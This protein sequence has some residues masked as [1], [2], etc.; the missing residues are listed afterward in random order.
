MI[1]H[2]TTPFLLPR[3]ISQ[4]VAEALASG[5]ISLVR[6]ALDAIRS[7][8]N[9]QCGKPFRLGIVRTFTIETQAEVIALAMSAL[10]CQIEIKIAD[11]ENIEQELVSPAS[12]L[13]LWG[14]DAVVVLWRLEELLPALRF[15]TQTLS[16]KIREATILAL[17][18]RINNLVS[19]YLEV[20]KVPLFISTLPLPKTNDLYDLHE[21]FGQRNAVEVVNAAVFNLVAKNSQISVFDFAGW[22][23]KI[24]SNSFDIKMDLYVRQP[25]ATAAIGDFS[26]FLAR[27]LRPLIMPAAKVLAIDLDNVL[28]GGVLGEDGINGVKISHDFPGN[29]YRRIQQRVLEFKACG[30]LLVLVSKNNLEDVN[31]AFAR[32]TDMPLKLNDFNEICVNWKEK[33]HNLADIAKTICLGLD[34][35]VFVDDQ[36][37]EREQMQFNLPEVTILEVSEDPMEILSALETTWM[38]D[39]IRI[40]EE[41]LSRHSDYNFQTQRKKLEE[42][43]SSTE[44][45]LLTLKLR[46]RLVPL[47]EQGVGRV[48]QMLAKTNQFNVTTRRHTESVLRAILNNS[49][50]ILLTISV[51]DRFGDQG[52]VGLIIALAKESETLHLDSFL[53]SCRALGR[54]V[55]DALW[56]AL[57]QEASSKEF[58]LLT[59]EYLRT[60]KNNQVEN[61]FER[62]GMERVSTDLGCTKY[63]LSLPYLVKAPAWIE[64]I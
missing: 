1:I 58:K 29:V 52:V 23:A 38:F 46:A 60:P 13:L 44:A 15:G 21:S 3:D 24:G 54:G 18:E 20:S 42:S 16:K 31:N 14:P 43:S 51:A 22:A 57:L 56:A 28:W 37:F 25:I 2:S 61:L 12:E 27:T 10:P 53:L 45:F 63:N 35:F 9:D 55:E 33:H 50:N 36:A 32:L 11:L 40:S 34:S 41:D 47:E 49:K 19:G 39:R 17:L 62:L 7:L 26:I 48:M 5:R 59:A 30:V 6:N 64:I 8:P 4:Q